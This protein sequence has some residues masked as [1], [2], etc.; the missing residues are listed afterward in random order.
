MPPKLV[1]SSVYVK[2]R[3]LATSGGHA[4]TDQK[5]QKQISGFDD[6]SVSIETEYMFAKGEAKYD[7]PKLV[8]KPETTQKEC[9]DIVCSELVDSVV[10]EGQNCLV[11]AYGQSGTGKTRTML[12]TDESLLQK[13][14][15]EDWGLFPR[16]GQEI[17]ARCKNKFVLT[18]SAVE[19]YMG[20]CFDLLGPRGKVGIDGDTRQPFGETREHLKDPTELIPV[21]N[22]VMANRSVQATGLNEGSSRSH[23]ALILNLAQ[24]DDQNKY[25]NTTF[26]LVDLAGA[27]RSDKVEK[28]P[29]KGKEWMEAD[30][31]QSLAAMKQKQMEAGD[32]KTTMKPGEKSKFGEIP[33]NMTGKVINGELSAI[34][35]EVLKAKDKYAAGQK[36][37]PPKQLVTPTIQFLGGIFDGSAKLSMVITL[38]LASSNGWETWFSLQYGTDLAKLKVPLKPQKPE[39]LDK[40]LEKAEKAAAFAKK[41]FED[42]PKNKYYLFRK[43]KAEA[44]AEAVAK[45]KMIQA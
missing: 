28:K 17:F 23:A 5:D 38:S 2:I 13:E 18:M 39:A 34:A 11:F 26:T 45:I 9:F 29:A 19:F 36:Y 21:L 3:P 24:L 41:E 15:H 16:V 30:P 12:G 22:A 6:T 42:K 14:L 4:E 33:A 25:I 7:F 37:Q 27:E 32:T 44:T 10:S 20:D 40:V 35:V 8:M 43:A 31:M 1:P